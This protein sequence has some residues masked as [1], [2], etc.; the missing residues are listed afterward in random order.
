MSADHTVLIVGAGPT[1]LT[2]ACTLLRSGVPV[3][4]VDRRRGPAT[5]PKALVLWSGALEVLDRLDVAAPLAERAL[6]LAGASYWSRGRKVAKVRF[7]GLGNTRFPGP[8]CVPQP[9][10]EELL[11]ARLTQLGGTVAWNT[12]VSSVTQEADGVTALL[13]DV[14]GQESAT[15]A[16]WL[17]AADGMHSTVRGTLGVPF[18]GATYPRDFLLGDVVLDPAGGIELPDHEAQY[19]LTPEGV[20]V[21]VSLPEG[22]HRVFFDQPAGTREDRPEKPELQQLLDA[23]GPGKWRISEVWWSSRFQVHTKVAASF[24]S[25]RVFLAGDA[26]HVHSPAGGQGLNTGVQDGF[27]IG[28]KL[29]AAVRS[30]D[31]GLL[32]SYQHER[33]PAAVGAVRNADRQTK[34]WLVRN[35]LVRRLR[36]VL[37]GRLSS[38]GAL[39]RRIIPELAQIDLDHTGSPVVQ[40]SSAP[41]DGVRPG[42]R[43]PDLPLTPVHGTKATTLHAYLAAGR[44]TVVVLDD[45]RAAT[46]AARAAEEARGRAH[47]ELSDVLLVRTGPTETPKAGGA[48]AYDL[49]TTPAGSTARTAQAVYVRPDGTV[50]A[51][52]PLDGP[53]RVAELLAHLPVLAPAQS[54]DL[55]GQR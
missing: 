43:V 51:R 37:L 1:G 22:G 10:T 47:P 45:G 17:I 29:A 25:G 41:A 9:V 42:R 18:E 7:G 49:A 8:L 15:T 31:T 34:L 26:A 4:V 23:R 32:D 48:P 30:G 24:R 39:E 40:Q 21:V 28:W 36:D 12:E 52:V 11:Y 46:E 16:S 20:L 35:P 53:G 14:D 50:G 19:H 2:A 55:P 27:D 33:R 3:H 38:S 6:P 13:R 5:A 44:H 54:G